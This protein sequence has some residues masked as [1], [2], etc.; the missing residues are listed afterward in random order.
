MSSEE[1]TVNLTEAE[2]RAGISR[3]A[4]PLADEKLTGRAL[5]LVRKAAKA[6][7]IRRGV[8]EVIKGLRKN[9]KGLM[10]LAGNVTPIDVI[11][12]IPVLCEENNIPYIYVPAKE[13]LGMSLV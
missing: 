5:K 7:L 8:K 2:F 9:E 13:D 1:K 3:I 12:H 4:S 6:K 11:S 10:I